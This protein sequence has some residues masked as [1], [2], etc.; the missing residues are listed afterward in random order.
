[1]PQTLAAYLGELKG[2]AAAQLL[3]LASHYTA[4]K[5]E[6]AAWRGRCPLPT[7]TDETP[8]FY[9]YGH[10][11]A[12]R[13]KCHGCGAGG[14]AVALVAAVE[15]L[16]TRGKGFADTL[17]RV[18]GLVGHTP[19]P[20]TRTAKGAA[21]RPLPPRLP[22]PSYPPPPP[23]KL[24][25]P[26]PPHE[27]AATLG[28]VHGTHLAGWLEGVAQRLGLELAAAHHTLEAYRVGALDAT[29]VVYWLHDAQGLA[30]N[31]EKVAYKA[32][33]K[34]IRPTDP[35]AVASPWLAHPTPWLKQSQDAKP[36]PCLFGAHLL[37]HRPLAPVCVVEGAKTALAAALAWPDN[38][39]VAITGAGGM[40]DAKAAQLAG[41]RVYL[42]LDKDAAGTRGTVK[43]L[44]A[45]ERVG[46]Y[47]AN[48][49]DL[50]H[51][52]PDAPKGADLA[53]WLQTLEEP[54]QPKPTNAA[55][56]A[57]TTADLPQSATPTPPETVTPPTPSLEAATHAQLLERNPYLATVADRLGLKVLE[58]Y[59]LGQTVGNQPLDFVKTC[60]KTDPPS[61]SVALEP[62]PP[63]AG[64]T[65]AHVLTFRAHPTV[66]QRF[67]QRVATCSLAVPLPRA[68]AQLEA[69]KAVTYPT[70]QLPTDAL[71][72]ATWRTY[73]LTA[74]G[75]LCP[76]FA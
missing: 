67:A 71:E 25:E 41:R 68:W 57:A 12:T 3:E 43:A 44:A 9:V 35:Q 11:D 17:A 50:A 54:A 61:W 40:S 38:V 22:P 70:A 30:C 37:E 8:S 66:A 63:L 4:L 56:T 19:P 36:R 10:G 76:A 33:G 24:L 7:H 2:A 16:P 20:S 21:G 69:G 31:G 60:A 34:R 48:A 45:L 1:M 74:H 58:V 53:D 75:V 49:V 6:G 65:R 62:V 59:P 28:K 23:P 14:D 72:L 18:A 27:V 47:T 5:R 13:W 32:N 73:T 51:V 26:V 42:L 52:W 15:A 55:H 39:W 46:N 64:D 29:R